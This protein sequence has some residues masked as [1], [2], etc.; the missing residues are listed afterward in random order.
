MSQS[1]HHSDWATKGWEIRWTYLNRGLQP[2]QATSFRRLRKALEAVVKRIP[3]SRPLHG[4]ETTQTTA[5]PPLKPPYTFTSLQIVE[6]HSVK[7]GW[8]DSLN[9][10]Q[11]GPKAI[12]SYQLPTAA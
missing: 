11:Q 7:E 12:A 10:S 3:P 1:L 4:P 8:E 6:R 5:L 9:I 2:L